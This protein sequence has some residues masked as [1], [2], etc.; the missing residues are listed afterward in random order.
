MINYKLL[1]PT[2]RNRYQFIRNCLEKYGQGSL[3]MALNL[4]TGEGD[5]DAMISRFTEKLIGCDINQADI[6]F[7]RE[8]NSNISNLSYQIEDALRLSFDNN[9]FDLI[10]SVEVIEHVGKPEKMIQEISRVLKPGG[11]VFIT[12]PQFNFPITY[13]PVNKLFRKGEQRVIAEGAYAFGHEYLI[14]SE[15]FE[16]WCA[17]NHLEIVENRPLSRSLV[18]LLEMYWTGIMQRLLKDNAK[19][20]DAKK[21]KKLVLRPSNQEPVLAS[22]T[23]GIIKLDNLLFQNTTT[24]VGKGYVLRKFAGNKY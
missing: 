18:G 4:G 1:F 6:E 19:N 15:E 5:Y 11:L 23:D 16:R 22:I 14:K 10:V 24:S 13:D 3:K 21:K 7:A 20:V 12:F 9:Q 2:F 17:E 8:L